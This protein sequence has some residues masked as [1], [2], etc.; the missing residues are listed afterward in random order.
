MNDADLMEELAA[1]EAAE[2]FWAF[3]RYMNPKMKLGWWQREVAEVLQTFYM[4]LIAGG[5]PKYVIQAPPQHGKSF[6]IIDFICWLFGKNPD[7]R[8]IYAAFSERLGVRANLRIQRI[9]SSS[10]YRR[11]FPDA[12]LAGTASSGAKGSAI[13]NRDTLELVNHEGIFRN[14]TI[15][16]PITGEGLD[17]GI[18]DD[19]IKGRAE[20]SSKTVR[21]STWDWLTDDFFSRFSEEAGLLAI[22]T[23]WHV[24]DPIG[25]LIEH[26][27]DV[28][29]FSYAAIAVKDEKH[30]KKGEA[31]FP[32]HKSV[33][34]L[35][36][37][38]AVMANANW[39]ALYQQN[40][41]IIGGELIHSDQFGRY[42]VL[43]NIIFRCIFADTAQKTAEHNDYSVFESW[44]MGDDNR[45]YLLDLIRDKWE[46]PQLETKAVDF[47]NKHRG[48]TEYGKYGPLRYLYVEDAVSG[49]GL[50]QSVKQKALAPIIPVDRGSNQGKL[51]RVMDVLG[52]IE[53]GMVMIPDPSLGLPWVS[54]FTEE[55]DAFTANDSHDYDDQV[56]P[57]VDAI[58]HMLV[59]G[60]S[61][62]RISQEA[63]NAFG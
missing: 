48:L 34:F 63:V 45:I 20:A 6:Q 32:E 11:V 13:R 31:L 40:P 43:P 2:S 21:D 46:A 5:R 8:A 22:L 33:E 14:T 60:V 16:G 44:G 25:R 56:D 59:V 27:P 26:M 36:E 9:M 29:V 47:W 24:D 7:M 28:K 62:M 58:H 61:S 12:Y 19:P 41:Q 53:A 23:R 42:K 51:A 1:A 39:E 18:I 30:R 37:R 55:C 38:K 54:D 50:I 57:M 15:R 17:L 4:E 35:L 52:Y 49:T 3:R 10:K